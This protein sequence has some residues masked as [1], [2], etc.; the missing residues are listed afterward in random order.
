MRFTNAKQYN[1]TYSNFVERYYSYT[2]TLPDVAQREYTITEGYDPYDLTYY[3]GSTKTVAEIKI[4]NISS[5]HFTTGYLEKQKLDS[6]LKLSI[7]LNTPDIHY[8]MYYSD[9]V[10]AI[11]NL[12][13]FLDLPTLQR[14][15]PQ[16]TANGKLDYVMKEVIELPLDR[17]MKFNYNIPDKKRIKQEFEKRFTLR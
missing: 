5:T 12:R 10:V 3:S 17:A 8:Q 9:G 14:R 4:R 2:N 13:G 11:W 15:C 16:T 1:F 7:Q 6:L